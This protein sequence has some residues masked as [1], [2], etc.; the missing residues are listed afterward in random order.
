M[1]SCRQATSHYPSQCWPTL[2]S[3]IVEHAEI[4]EHLEEIVENLIV[5]H[6]IYTISIAT[7]NRTPGIFFH[8]VNSQTRLTIRD[9]RVG[10]CHHDMT[11]LGQRVNN[12]PLNNCCFNVYQTITNKAN[13]RDLIAATGLVI[14]LKLD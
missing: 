10:P 4:D 2:V 11:S 12:G 1:A 8:C 14:L 13:L 5:E 9:T 3:Q 6:L 7:N